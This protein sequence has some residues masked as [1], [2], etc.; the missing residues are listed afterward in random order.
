MKR[1]RWQF[2]TIGIA[3]AALVG[4]VLAAPAS[5]AT[6][7]TAAF[8]KTSDWGSGYE[9]KYTISNG[10]ASALTSWTVEFT[11]PSGQSIAS[12]WDGSYTASG[13]NIT[14]KNT[15]NGSIGVGG[16]A[17]F[18]FTVRGSG[19]NPANCKVN[20]AACDGTGNPPTTTT[21][22]TTTTVEPSRCRAPVA[23]RRTSTWAGATRRTRRRS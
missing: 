11:L 18:G 16:S 13:Q 10:G 8:I 15:W 2:L 17:S 3:V 23:A 6:G 22:T 12:L 19:A 20:G 1:F 14:V 5:G 4:G 9:A 21:T 7:V